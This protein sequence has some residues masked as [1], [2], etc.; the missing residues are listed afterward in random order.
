MRSSSADFNPPV[1]RLI[2][3]S[4]EYIETVKVGKRRRAVRKIKSECLL[5]ITLSR[6]KPPRCV[7][8][9]HALNEML[10]VFTL[11]ILCVCATMYILPAVN[12][13]AWCSNERT[14]ER[15]WS[16]GSFVTSKSDS[17]Y[18]RLLSCTAFTV[19]A[20]W[21]IFVSVLLGQLTRRIN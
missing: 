15:W 19:L 21:L 1:Q 4:L 8:A 14:M 7:C 6:M 16:S 17:I 11:E 10:C 2:N 5:D 20:S 13:C 3:A 12:C 9:Q 18:S